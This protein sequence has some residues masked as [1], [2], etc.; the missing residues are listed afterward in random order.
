[1]TEQRTAALSRWIQTEIE[2]G[3]ALTA[4]V[5]NYLEATFGTADLRDVLQQADS[6]EIDSLL[7]LIFYPDR[8]HQVRFEAKWGRQ[9]FTEQERDTV[10]RLLCRAAPVAQLALPDS[11]VNIAIPAPEF[12][13][14]AFVRRLNMCWQPAPELDQALDTCCPGEKALRLRVAMRNARL[15]WHRDQVTLVCLYLRK[16][17]LDAETLL[18]DLQFLLSLLCEFPAESDPYTFL[19]GKKFF[20]FKSLCSAEEYERRR[21]TSNMEIMMMQGARS[22]HGSIDQWRQDMRSID[23]ICQAL[24]GR[25]QF[26]QQPDSHCI[27]L[28]S[29]S[30]IADISKVLT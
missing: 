12:A 11:P 13:L 22:A 24:F 28:Q 6:S 4:D 17:P 9:S 8:S 1:M 23:R 27:D 20:Y 14:H 21:S 10:T 2:G 3:L 30:S 26:F 16:M 15:A 19:I 25:T 18:S 7:E 5:L 29:G